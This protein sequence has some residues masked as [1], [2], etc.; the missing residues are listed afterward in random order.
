MKHRYSEKGFMRWIGL[1]H[2]RFQPPLRIKSE[3]PGLGGAQSDE[4]KLGVGSMSTAS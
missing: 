4:S 1:A 2:L 3:P